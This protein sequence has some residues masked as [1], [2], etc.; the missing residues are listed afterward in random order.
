VIKPEQIIVD[1]LWS[2]LD[3]GEA[4]P[5]QR[6]PDILEKERENGQEVPHYD[7]S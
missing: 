7:A 4:I 3:P 2:S 5:L 6:Y 1:G